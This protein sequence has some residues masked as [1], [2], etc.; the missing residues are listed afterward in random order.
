MNCRVWFHSL[1][2]SLFWQL[3]FNTSLPDI[4]Q[5]QR[6]PLI[7][8]YPKNIITR[9]IRESIFW[10]LLFIAS[11]FDLSKHVRTQ[12]CP[13]FNFVLHEYHY[14]GFTRKIYFD[15]CS[16]MHRL[17]TWAGA[18]RPGDWIL[19][20]AFLNLGSWLFEA[21]RRSS[22][23]C[24]HLLRCLLTAILVSCIQNCF[25]LIRRWLLGFLLSIRGRLLALLVIVVLLSYHAKWQLV[26]MR[27]DDKPRDDVM[28]TWISYIRTED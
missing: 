6:I 23:W 14:Q 12:L 4:S 20:E 1:I 9:V 18:P 5:H 15:S 2:N 3:L 11:I 26:V 27:F 21:D 25:K 7:T 22:F 17:L 19:L 24:H 8:S 28:S 10:Q 16:W 13:V